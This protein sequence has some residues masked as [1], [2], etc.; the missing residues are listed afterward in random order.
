MQCHNFIPYKVSISVTE[1]A[2]LGLV[3]YMLL[4]NE[5][6]KE[7]YYVTLLKTSQNLIYTRVGIQLSMYFSDVLSQLLA[8]YVVHLNEY[9]STCRITKILERCEKY[10]NTYSDTCSVTSLLNNIFQ[11]A[12][13]LGLFRKWKEVETGCDTEKDKKHW[14]AMWTVERPTDNSETGVLSW[15]YKPMNSMITP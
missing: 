2:N 4:W 8:L 9:P 15:L 11:L 12:F 13:W 6:Q 7:W 5:N 10:E 3:L 14:G 1:K